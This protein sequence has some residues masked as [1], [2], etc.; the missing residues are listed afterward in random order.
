MGVNMKGAWSTLAVRH[1]YWTFYHLCEVILGST[2]HKPAADQGRLR[3]DAY[4]PAG[5]AAEHH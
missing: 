5:Y 3:R 4:G 2:T 1:V